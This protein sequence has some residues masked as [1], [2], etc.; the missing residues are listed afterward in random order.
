MKNV[1]LIFL[2]MVLGIINTTAQEVDTI[3]VNSTNTKIDSLAVKLSNL[4]HD[5]D[6]LYCRFL[7]NEHKIDLI[8]LMQ[9]A[10]NRSLVVNSFHIFR[11]D[12]YISFKE[13]YE[14]SYSLF[15]TIKNSYESTKDLILSKIISSNFSEKEWDLLTKH[16]NAVDAAVSATEISLRT[17]KSSID[18]YKKYN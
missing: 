1:I 3:K 16:L 7:L 6:F 13:S 14:S 2:F 10:N 9:D 12:L 11:T 17:Y 4:Q 5:Y 18:T 8:Y 15:E